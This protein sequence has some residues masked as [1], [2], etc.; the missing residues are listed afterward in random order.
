MAQILC[1]M[2]SKEMLKNVFVWQGNNRSIYTNR[3]GSTKTSRA[4]KFVAI[5]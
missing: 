3:W 1:R 4:I 2:F 5:I